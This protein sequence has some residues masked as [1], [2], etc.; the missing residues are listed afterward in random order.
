MEVTHRP[1]VYRAAM[2]SRDIADSI[3][4]FS[5]RVNGHYPSECRQITKRVHAGQTVPGKRR[6][7]RSVADWFESCSQRLCGRKQTN[8]T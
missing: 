8:E 1:Q 2:V 4:E 3:A 6:K 7:I 5:N